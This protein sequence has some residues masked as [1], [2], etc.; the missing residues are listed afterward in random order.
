MRAWR[1]D[2]PIGLKGRAW[3]I[4][5]RSPVEVVD[6]DGVVISAPIAGAAGNGLEGAFRGHLEELGLARAPS[7]I[8]DGNHDRRHPDH[9]A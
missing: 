3:A 2:V 7:E 5:L 8:H 6:G 9:G 4:S 1:F